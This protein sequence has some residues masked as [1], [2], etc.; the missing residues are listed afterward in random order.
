MNGDLEEAGSAISLS[1]QQDHFNSNE[2]AKPAVLSSASDGS[3]ATAQVVPK[4]KHRFL[5]ERI[6][7]RVEIAGLWLII[8]VALG[9]LCLPIVFYHIRSNEVSNCM[10]ALSL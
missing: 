8:L 10:F 3:T 4:Y 5:D 6:Q 2:V 1:A 7:K 9:L